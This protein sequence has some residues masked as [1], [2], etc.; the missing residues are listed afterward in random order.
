[1]SVHEC[2][3][4]AVS[5]N[6]V[7]RRNLISSKVPTRIGAV[8]GNVAKGTPEPGRM[9][10]D[11]QAYA[12]TLSIPIGSKRVEGGQS[13]CFK[14]QSTPAIPEALARTFCKTPALAYKRTG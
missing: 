8:A 9:H 14:V 12:F 1:M 13:R 4:Y 11:W 6:A 5:V 2:K 10:R 3:V 7:R